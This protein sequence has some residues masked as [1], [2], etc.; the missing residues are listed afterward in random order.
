MIIAY[1]VVRKTFVGKQILDFPSN[2]GDAV[3]GTILGIGYIIAF[4]NALMIVVGLFYALMAAYLVSH[5]A[6]S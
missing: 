2:L 4:I 3:P 5:V 1:L 6:G